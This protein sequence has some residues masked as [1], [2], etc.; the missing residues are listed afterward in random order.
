MAGYEGYV[1]PVQVSEQL[2]TREYDAK[3]GIRLGQNDIKR[4]LAELSDP[5]ADL[6]IDGIRFS[7]K[8]KFDA[9]A[10]MMLNNKMSTTNNMID[11]ITGLVSASLAMD[12]TV[13]GMASA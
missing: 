10:I 7:P 9:D 6:I 1:P 5:N 11:A 3:R 2:N 13:S 12:K 8:R 4:M